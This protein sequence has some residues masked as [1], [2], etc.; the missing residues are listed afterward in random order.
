MVCL[1]LCYYVM[2]LGERNIMIFREVERP[3]RK[4][5]CLVGSHGSLWFPVTTGFC[6]YSLG[7]DLLNWNSFIG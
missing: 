6:N 4:V 1:S 7:L 3:V 5:Q 2:A